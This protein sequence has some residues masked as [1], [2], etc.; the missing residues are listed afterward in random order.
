LAG[1]ILR[2]L[3]VCYPECYA[4][5]H[6]II[7]ERAAALVAE[8]KW[9]LKSFLQS[10]LSLTWQTW[11]QIPPSSIVGCCFS[12][13]LVDAFPVHRVAIA[14]GQLQE[15]FVTAQLQA[16]GSIAWS[17]I[18]DRPSTPRLA[19][20][21]QLIGIDL[22]SPS[23]QD[24]YRTEVNLAALDWLQTVADRLRQGYILTLDY[25]YPADRY[26]HPNRRDGTL[27]CYY[28]H[29]HHD[30]PYFSIGQQDMTAHVDFTALERQGERCG[31]RTVGFTKQG[32]FLMALGLGD[33]IAA[34]S[35]STTTQPQNVLTVLQRRDALHQ[36]IDPMGLGSFGVLIQSKGMDNSEIL[37]GLQGEVQLY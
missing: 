1:D 35:Q 15:I 25:G 37:L 3:Q 27:Q 10:G 36:L 14:E 19:E 8:Q 23:Y 18:L 4:S 32:L 34:L 31:L 7:L 21:F 28:R 26:Y 17:E 29:A 5:L 24:S 20:Y 13:E 22:T 2:H 9:Q 16:D 30:N 11:E 33:R 12:N 6:Y